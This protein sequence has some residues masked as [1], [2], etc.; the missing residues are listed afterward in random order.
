VNTTEGAAADITAEAPY[1]GYVEFGRRAIDLL[2]TNRWLRWEESGA[3]VFAQKVRAV[4]P[5]HFMTDALDEAG[6]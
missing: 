1:A 6:D 4:G 5:T 3:E 2:G